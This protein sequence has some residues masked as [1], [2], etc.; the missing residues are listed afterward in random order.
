[1]FEQMG[2]ASLIQNRNRR[3]KN[4]HVIGGKRNKAAQAVLRWGMAD[5]RECSR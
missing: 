1:M 2:L 3:K 4:Y 5:R